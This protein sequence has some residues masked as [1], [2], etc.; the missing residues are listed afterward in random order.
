[1]DSIPSQGNEIFIQMYILII[2]SG[3]ENK[4]GVTQ[5]AISPV[6]GEKY[7]MECNTKFPLKL[8]VK[9]ILLTED[10]LKNT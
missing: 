4:R 2:R 7:G 8:I 9:L 3:I 5:H 10:D 1:M 6:L